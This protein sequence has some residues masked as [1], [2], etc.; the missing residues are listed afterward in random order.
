MAGDLPAESPTPPDVDSLPPTEYLALET[1][2]ARHRL[3]ERTWTF[4]AQPRIVAAV[5]ALARRG[6]V[7]VKSGTAPKTILAWLTEAGRAAA[8]RDDYEPPILRMIEA[9]SLGTPEAKA[10]R[11][12]VSDEVA[13]KIVARS[14]ELAGRGDLP[15]GQQSNLC[16]INGQS[17]CEWCKRQGRCT[18]QEFEREEAEVDRALPSMGRVTGKVKIFTEDGWTAEVARVRA[19]VA[20]DLRPMIEALA[21]V[22]DTY[23]EAGEMASVEDANAMR[24]AADRGSASPRPAPTLSRRVR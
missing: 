7:D 2:A 19:E 10:L 13:K 23:F 8:L 18:G 24:A 6:L 22:Y 17:L 11:A 9:S 1:L 16:E 12:S 21:R 15:E 20:E 5:H 14:K 4:P 3:G